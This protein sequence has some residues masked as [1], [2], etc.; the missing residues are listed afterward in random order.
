MGGG[1]YGNSVMRSGV[2]LLMVFFLVLM[3]GGPLQAQMA[4]GGDSAVPY[5]SGQQQ[6]A[7]RGTVT[8]KGGLPL[9]G[10]SV[11]VKGTTV[12]VTTDSEGNFSFQVP[13]GS[14]VL[15]VSFVGMKTVEIPVG[16]QSVFN[17]VLEEETI[18]LDEVVVVGYGTV[19]K[20][21]VTGALTSVTEKAIKERPVQNALQAMQGKAAGVDIVSNVRP[22]ETASINIR[23]TRSINGSN[24][25]L[26]VVDGIILMGSIN[27]I[28]PNDIASIEILKDASATAIY[29]S[30]GANG[31]VLVTTK[32]GRQGTVSVNYDATLSIDRV[33]SLTDWASSGEAIDRFRL[34]DRK[35][36][37]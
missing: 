26:F 18:G 15:S 1:A 22:G 31:V 11:V 37:V 12:G 33:H 21:D 27:D 36:V 4:Y 30:R 9:P 8:D 6:R 7:V 25:P 23:G 24:S 29:G 16:N 14:A 17:I 5:D 10:V 19:K 2:F 13:P 32:S 3:V 20:S 28:N 35:S 34:A